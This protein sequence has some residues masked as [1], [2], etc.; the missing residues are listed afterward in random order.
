[1]EREVALGGNLEHRAIGDLGK[2]DR[3]GDGKSG[4]GE[5]VG[6]EPAGLDGGI[7][8]ALVAGQRLRVYGEGC[9]GDGTTGDGERAGHVRGAASRFHLAGTSELFFDPVPGDGLLGPGSGGDGPS[10]VQGGGVYAL[11]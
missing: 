2:G 8:A 6:L 4:F 9:F 11:A 5:G 3:L 1:M 7:A 10:A